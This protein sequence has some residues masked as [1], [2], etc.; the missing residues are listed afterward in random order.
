MDTPI[1]PMHAY[2]SRVYL[3]TFLLLAVAGFAQTQKNIVISDSLAAHAEELKVK[4]GSQMIGKT[5]K[6]RFGDYRIVSGKTGWTTTTEKSNFFNTKTESKSTGRF[7][8]VLS[9]K[10]TDYASVNAVNNMAI[11]SLHEVEL[12]PHVWLGS[13]KLLLKTQNFSAFI[14]IN[15]DTS[16]TWALF[17][18]LE[19][20]SNINGKDEA[21]LTNGDRII[22]LARVNSNQN[23]NDPRS[24]PALGY[25]FIENSQSLC[26][27]Q[28]YG[29]GA[30]GMNKNIVWM[31]K[32]LDAKMNL[33]LA[34]AMA[35]I[36][37]NNPTGLE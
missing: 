31:Y 21:L 2:L 36:L 11:E 28:Y 23:G 14:T 26:A 33:V 16:E 20:G 18:D 6:I 30:L 37:Q 12:I 7:S 19:L 4:M 13:N 34:A 8:F 29:G 25:E 10:G 35:A 15:G 24:I 32:G 22:F 9:N 5:F 27:L 1:S 17:M 3:P